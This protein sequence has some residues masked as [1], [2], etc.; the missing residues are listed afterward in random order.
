VAFSLSPHTKS[1]IIVVIVSFPIGQ[2]QFNE[3]WTGCYSIVS[4]I[5][6]T[7]FFNPHTN[8]FAF[9]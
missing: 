2:L 8:V 3:R 9:W 5:Y 1:L 7:V 4:L 6:V